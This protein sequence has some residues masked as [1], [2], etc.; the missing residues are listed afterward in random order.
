MLDKISKF[1]SLYFCFCFWYEMID[2][3]KVEITRK[4]NSGVKVGRNVWTSEG[5]FARRVSIDSGKTGVWVFNGPQIK[6]QCSRGVEG[7]ATH[8]F[9]KPISQGGVF[10]IKLQLRELLPVDHHQRNVW[11]VSF[12]RRTQIL[13]RDV[14]DARKN[15]G[16]RLY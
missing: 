15:G 6:C 11:K 12:R 3:W 4:F 13:E 14:W 10:L 2:H 16:Q 5:I 7:Q 1:F 9:I 8:L